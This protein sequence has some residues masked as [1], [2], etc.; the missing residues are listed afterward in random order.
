MNEHSGRQARRQTNAQRALV[1]CCI[2]GAICGAG[3]QLLN[4]IGGGVSPTMFGIAFAIFAPLL[5]IASVV[6]WRNIDEAAREAH[7]FAWLWGGSVAMLVVLALAFLVGDA[8]LVA[9][10]GERSPSGWVMFGV[11]SL[12]TAQMIGYGLV[13][14]GWW[15]RQR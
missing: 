12:T 10:M 15:L 4:D 14:A 9:W 13:W 8:R 2:L 11:L 7:K 5:G 6:Y 1:G 3:Y